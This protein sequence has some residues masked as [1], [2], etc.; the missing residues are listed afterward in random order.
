MKI[1]KIAGAAA[2]A[3]VLAGTS[4][5]KVTLPNYITPNMVV[6]HD[7]QLKVRGHAAPGAKVTITPSW[8]NKPL[9]TVADANGNFTAVIATPA[10]GGPFALI[11]DDGEQT[12]VDNILSGEVWLCS[13]Q[14]NMEFPIN[15]NLRI[16]NVD[17]VVAKAH[18]PDI[19]LLQINKHRAFTP[20]TD[21]KT[22]M[23]GWVEANS[24]TMNFSAI[25]YLFAKELR[26]SL[27]VPVGVI[28]A[29]WGGTPAESWTS[30]DTLRNIPG[31][32]RTLDDFNACGFDYY[33]LRKSYTTRRD[34]WK[35]IADAREAKV[36]ISGDLGGH[37]LPTGLFE[38]IGLGENLDG[39]VWAQKVIDV[40]ASLA[41]QQMELYL[42]PIDDE[43]ITYLNG[44]EVARGRGY[45]KTRIYNV[46]GKYVKAGKNYLTIRITDHNGEGG[47]AGK[48]QQMRAVIGD[49]TFALGDDWNYR[50]AVDFADLPV[51]PM[52]ID[53]P[54]QPT[55]L[56]NAMLSPLADMPIKGA[57]WYQG[58]ANVG[59]DEQYAQ[60]FPAMIRNWRALWGNEFPFYFV[61]LAGYLK[62]VTVQ[63]DSRWAALRNA[64]T[65]ALKLPNTAMVSAIDLGHPG[66]IHPRD[67]QT[68]AH[69]LA[70]TA[71]GRDYGHAADYAAPQCTG[72]KFSGNK[73]VLTFDRDLTPTSIAALGFIIGD[74]E[75]NFAQAM[76][77]M[78][79]SRT[80]V[81]CSP[82]IKRPDRAR[83]NWADYPNGNLYGSNGIPVAPFATDK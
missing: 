16:H 21:V 7:S 73:A 54:Y 71:L 64:Q 28:E 68:V 57:L 77:E 55:V 15:G 43:D 44:V 67:K 6:Q 42:G 82:L 5:A 17:E 56:Y 35:K 63:P 30:Y 62:P 81:L 31:F 59:R 51:K 39:V 41:G 10:P 46:P 14:S 76:T 53:S 38:K 34:E 20:Q 22:N 2:L 78:P 60:L 50:V 23:G 40:P 75:G 52:D 9:K 49:N 80:V 24:N 48:P 74:A 69:R 72:V 26:D 37:T 36:D 19:R 47:F 25:A 1:R 61:Q 58:C 13:G 32:E 29:S 45:N 83:Y 11:F 70:L 65:A 8:S 3:A 12:V 4:S 18:N 33:K 66:D 27:H 79:D